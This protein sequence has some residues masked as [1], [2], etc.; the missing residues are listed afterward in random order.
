MV[1]ALLVLVTSLVVAVTKPET[2]SGTDSNTAVYG[3][4]WTSNSTAFT[5]RL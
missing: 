2:H 1:A 5:G 4:R 3:S